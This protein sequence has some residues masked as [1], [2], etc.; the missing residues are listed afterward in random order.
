MLPTFDLFYSHFENVD[1]GSV[2]VHQLRGQSTTPGG[3][4]GSVTRP[5]SLSRITGWT[6]HIWLLF[7]APGSKTFP[8]TQIEDPTIPEKQTS[9]KTADASSTS[10]YVLKKGALEVCGSSPT[11]ASRLPLC[12]FGQPGSIPALV[13]HSGG[14][15][16]WHR[17]GAIAG[18]FFNLVDHSN[19][20]FF[21][22]E[23]SSQISIH[24]AKEL[25]DKI[26]RDS[27]SG[28]SANLLTGKSVVRTRPLHLVFTCLG[29]GSL[30]VSQPLYFLWVA[31]Q[32]GSER[33]LQLNDFS[34]N[35]KKI[36]NDQGSLSRGVH[37]DPQ[38]FHHIK[39]SPLSVRLVSKPRRPPNRAS[40]ALSQPTWEFISPATTTTSEPDVV[41][42][43]STA[44]ERFRPS[45]GLSRRRSPRVSVN[46]M[47][48]LNPSWNTLIRKSIC[49]SERLTWKLVYFANSCFS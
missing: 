8:V 22:V 26:W 6:V 23:C 45:W 36:T 39:R 37:S 12:K 40:A 2:R 10:G 15:V 49:F 29:L 24:T 11:S 31:R 30:T 42:N 21:L 20:L 47:F 27:S 35:R 46:L 16:V 25:T 33:V 19:G 32:L 34:P 7:S 17:K 14:M 43:S 38:F 3:T 41:G 4:V 48:Y 1:I 28:Q 9:A 18:R 5:P 44:H 13:L